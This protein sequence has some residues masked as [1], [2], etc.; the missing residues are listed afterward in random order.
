MSVVRMSSIHETAAVDAPAGSPPFLNMVVLGHTSLAPLTLLIALQSIEH[1]LG[2]APRRIHNEPRVIDLDLIAYGAMRMRTARLTLPHP[3]AHE[4]A[5]VMEPLR[6]LG[7]TAR[8]I[9]DS[10]RRAGL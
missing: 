4:R 5:F 8:R 2:R 1:H 10:L 3:R 6:E 9:A 7:E